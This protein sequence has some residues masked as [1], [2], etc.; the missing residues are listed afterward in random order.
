MTR[1]S[2]NIVYNVAGQGAVLIVSLIA[3]RFIFKHLGEDVFGIIFFNVVLTAVLSSV[4]ELGV[5]S[6][7][8]REVSS[9][10]DTERRYVDELIRTAS[11]VYWAIGLLLVAAIWLAAPLLVTRWINLHTMDPQSA[12]TM[13]RILSALALVALP[14]GLYT[15]LFRGRQMMSLNNAIDVGTALLQQAGILAL[16]ALASGSAY[17]VAAWMSISALLGIAAYI[18]VAARLFGW[19]ALV[20]RFSTYV[21][22]RNLGFTGNMMAV[23]VLSLV[24][25]QA[26]QVIVSKVMSI[27][28]FGYYGLV[29][30]TVNRATFVT[31]A[32]AQAAFPSF[33]NLFGLD[34]RDELLIQYRKLHDLVCFGT[35]PL[36]AG[37]C[38]AAIP[39]YSFIFGSG[40]IA[41]LLLL[42]TAFLALGSWMNATLTIPYMLSIAMGKAG[43]VARLNFYALFAVLPV[44]LILVLGFG[45]PGAGFSWVFYHLFAYAYMVPKIARECL[46]SSAP[47]W[48]GHVLRVFALG[49]AAYG[50]AWVAMNAIEPATASLPLAVAAYLL[51]TALFVGGAYVMIG[52]DLRSTIQRLPGTLAVRK[53]GAR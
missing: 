35:L 34:L 21:V 23:S 26:A 37:I 52:P 15:S 25:I 5:S 32:I 20:P 29:A 18:L 8:V 31:G 10:Y 28:Q 45:L 48:Y 38:F 53:A 7:I 47:S 9:R 42:P 49:L 51:G 33:S 11:G 41:R 13:L 22:R 36:F 44:T 6:T 24:H 39:V 43:I 17:T 4:L 40:S 27:G 46:K 12:A 3:V 1:L 30:S 19:R 14:K 2:R 16:L 50:I